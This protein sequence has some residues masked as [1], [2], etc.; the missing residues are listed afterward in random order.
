MNDWEFKRLLV[1]VLGIQFSLYV[2]IGLGS[3][4]LDVPF[5]RPL[6]GLIY[7]MF[8]P[9]VL[10]L[11]VFKIHG[12]SNVETIIY[13]SGLSIAT[14]MFIGLFSNTFFPFFGIDRPITT[15]P[16]LAVFTATLVVL[17]ILAYIRDRDFSQP[18]FVET[19]GIASP[20]VVFLCIIPFVSIAGAQLMNIA[21]DNR[22]SMLVLVLIASI[23]LLMI[24]GRIP[25][26]LYPLAVFVAAVAL[27]LNV[28]L[29]TPYV[30]GYDVQGEFYFATLIS[31]S[32]VWNSA[33][34][35]DYNSV[36][37]VAMLAPI[38]SVICNLSIAVVF[39]VI[40]Q[41]LFALVPLGLYLVYERQTSDKAAFLSVFYFVSIFSFYA[42]MTQMMRQ[43]IAELFVVLM[44]LLIIEKK[45]TNTKYLLFVIFG[46]GLIVSHYGLSFLYIV[47][48]IPA[49]LLL[50]SGR[51]LKTIKS[52]QTKRRDAIPIVFVVL[53][54]VLALLWY[55]SVGGS[56]VIG[57]VASVLSHGFSN[58]PD[59]FSPQIATPA[60]AVLLATS[61]MRE[62]TLCLSLIAGFF[63]VLGFLALIRRPREVP[64]TREYFSLICANVAVMAIGFVIPLL[65]QW[66]TLR[67]YQIALIA[68]APL[69][70]IGGM[71]VFKAI[72]R[73][74][75]Q[76]FTNKWEKRSLTAL[77]LFLAIF[78]LF[79]SGWMYTI[80]NDN[81]TQYALN[82]R[83]DAPRFSDQEMLAAKWIVSSKLSETWV[84]GD[85][86][87][88]LS[89]FALT[90]KENT[91]SFT[92]WRLTDDA[93][94][95][96]E[97]IVLFRRTNLEGSL[98]Q[99]SSSAS[100]VDISLNDTYFY[101]SEIV[102]AN[103]IYDN[104]AAR[105]YHIS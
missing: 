75:R 11:R 104:G 73:I 78:L 53:F 51:L 76:P 4:G 19:N 102:N 63:V 29:I 61:L 92:Q 5:L 35:N 100:V 85:E 32:G 62:I 57:T 45:M 93:S 94:H 1:A 84:A 79:N 40:Y 55:L 98:A 81:S 7:L 68:L 13:V 27:L 18:A 15:Q 43:E 71:V 14:V 28:S 83:A 72:S 59:I 69:F 21:G 82:S 10:L 22:L 9:G 8:I 37:S 36:L 44:I 97:V 66:N 33:I 34:P 16:L 48:L 67:A 89:F 103:L 47:L 101:R 41:V 88:W 30:A 42:V 46:F 54:I 95:G 91:T 24:F 49:L 2:L 64:F 52:D 25:K 86:Y 96:K 20:P 56:H 65:F 87:G 12:L 74:A 90:G 105:A 26:K 38:I 31:T 99:V 60:G 3:L 70:V 77:S 39:K 50:A 58:V 80:T 6:I 17:C 23:P